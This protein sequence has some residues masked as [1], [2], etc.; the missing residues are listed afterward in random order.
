M[1]H[2]S[3]LFPHDN[4]IN[5]H[6]NTQDARE[7][8]KKLTHLELYH[9]VKTIQLSF[10]KPM[11]MFLLIIVN[12]HASTYYVYISLKTMQKHFSPGYH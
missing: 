2:F 4:V 7:E 3:S 8:G 5:N 12:Y 11:E 9:A 1:L 10:R 6:N